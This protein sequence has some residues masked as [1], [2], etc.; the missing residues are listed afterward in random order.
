MLTWHGFHAA[1]PAEHRQT[2]S[3]AITI[4][5]CGCECTSTPG[6]WMQPRV[7]RLER[8]SICCRS[9]GLGS[10]VFL[11]SH[12]ES[13]ERY[14]QAHLS[15]VWTGDLPAIWAIGATVDM[16]TSVV[17]NLYLTCAGIN[18]SHREQFAYSWHTGPYCARLLPGNTSRHDARTY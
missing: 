2:T 18:A 11:A 15:M 14:I 16:M 8:W 6:P 13:H 17:G 9:A 1:P 3:V 4:P 12:G 10:G 5:G 7:A